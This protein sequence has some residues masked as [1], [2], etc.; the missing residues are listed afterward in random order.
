MF[1]G[2]FQAVRVL[3]VC[4]LRLLEHGLNMPKHMKILKDQECH[5]WPSG[6]LL[7][8]HW[9]TQMAPFCTASDRLEL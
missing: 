8:E 1:L 3:H 2:Q 4:L 7:L 6:I 5:L 9:L